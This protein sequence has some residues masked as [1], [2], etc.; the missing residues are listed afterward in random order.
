MEAH[1]GALSPCG[2]IVSC[3]NDILTVLQIDHGESVENRPV[4]AGVDKLVAGN[5]Y[6]ADAA[7]ID[8]LAVESGDERA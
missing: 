8:E 6:R 4:I 1:R 7:S 2:E 5:L 3:Q